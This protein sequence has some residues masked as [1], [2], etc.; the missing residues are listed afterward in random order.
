M[1]TLP[2]AALA[3]IAST[4]M[5]LPPAPIHRVFTQASPSVVTVKSIGYSKDMFA[6]S[7]MRPHMTG[8]GT[9]F[10]V[11]EGRVLTNRHVIER[12]D[13]IT[14]QFS[15]GR[16]AQARLVGIDDRR[17]VALLQFDEGVA[18]AP[19]LRFCDAPAFVGEQVVAIGTP[20]GLQQSI[21]TGVISGLGRSVDGA[22]P[23]LN[24]LQTDAALNPGN[25]G[26]PLLDHDTGCVLGMNTATV[27][28]GVGLAI[29]SEDLVTSLARLSG[30]GHRPEP[31]GLVLM[32][33]EL[34][35]QLGLPGLAVIATMEGSVAESL[36]IQ[37]TSRDAFGRPVFGDIIL[38]VNGR[39]VSSSAD[40]KAALET[41]EHSAVDILLLRGDARVTLHADR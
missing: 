35:E 19:P 33:D 38:E 29:P 20:F 37:G 9:G 7:S 41:A 4:Q 6:F 25:S 17:D 22:P 12:A 39:L 5:M 36:G 23:I 1:K 2:A 14:L 40:L 24:M 21:S 28:P 15:N 26:G 8:V 18:T 27:G 16:E 10:V 3:V 13:D 34:T 32:P 11:G 31:L 30:D